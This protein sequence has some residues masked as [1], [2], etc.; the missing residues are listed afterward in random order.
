MNRT[1]DKNGRVATCKC[2]W[3]MPQSMI[4]ILEVDCPDKPSEIT[5][6]MAIPGALIILDCPR[7]GRP[8]RVKMRGTAI[9]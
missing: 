1:P 7:C 6:A 9:S 2:G 8:H 5:E 4:P 3:T